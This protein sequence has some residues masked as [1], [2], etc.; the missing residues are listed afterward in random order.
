MAI[1]YRVAAEVVDLHADRPSPGEKFL[2]DTNVWYWTSYSRL[3]L[4]PPSRQPKPYQLT[5][6][7]RYLKQLLQVGAEIFWCGLALSELAHLIEAAE[8]QIWNVAANTSGQGGGPPKEFRHNFP[9]ERAHVVAEITTAWADVNAIGKVL[10]APLV[11]DHQATVQ[12]VTDM[13]SFPLDG[14]D[15]FFFRSAL[16]IGIPQIIS[17]DGDFCT[18]PGIRLFTR[19]KSVLQAAAAQNKILQR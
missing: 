4:T 2:V 1:N 7:P 6:Y 9:S 13:Q 14:Y 8:Y 3:S 16:T 10:P 17:D 12:A 19:N 11:I 18:L 15:L 5:D